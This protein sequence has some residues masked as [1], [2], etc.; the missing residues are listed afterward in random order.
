MLRQT[1]RCI[2]CIFS[3]LSVKFYN[4]LFHTPRK[5]CILMYT[6][7]QF[8]YD[9]IKIISFFGIVCFTDLQNLCFTELFYRISVILIDIFL[10][11][12]IIIDFT[13]KSHNRYSWLLR[14][15]LLIFFKA[16]KNHY[17]AITTK[18]DISEMNIF[19]S[20]F[21]FTASGLVAC[22]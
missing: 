21:S 22:L 12:Y 4:F 6:N 10:D 14:V 17:D 16:K 20:K 18:Y 3:K 11:Y 2:Y 8:Y 5:T 19:Y 15:G 1:C 13:R 7:E 9:C